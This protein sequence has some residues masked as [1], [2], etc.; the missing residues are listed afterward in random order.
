M[1]M[2]F[3]FTP[4]A[5]VT[6]NPQDHMGSYGY[7]EDQFEEFYA[8]VIANHGEEIVKISKATTGYFDITFGSGLTLYAISGMSITLK[9]V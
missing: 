3:I 7:D 4:E 6:R 5:D 1:E 9:S 2:E 8:D